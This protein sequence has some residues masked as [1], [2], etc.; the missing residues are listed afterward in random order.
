MT[1]TGYQLQYEMYGYCA[2][3]HRLPFVRGVGINSGGANQ[4]TPDPH[5]PTHTPI[6][7]QS[8]YKVLRWRASLSNEYD[9]QT[10]AGTQQEKERPIQ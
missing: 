4:H 3:A 1:A 5:P 2:D 8:Q 9:P 10:I 7:T 6:S